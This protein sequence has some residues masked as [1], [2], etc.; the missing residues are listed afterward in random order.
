MGAVQE[1]LDVLR[2]NDRELLALVQ[3]V[4]Y[5]E[6]LAWSDSLTGL[7]NRRGFNEE[8]LREDARAQRYTTPVSVVLVDVVGLK[9]VNDRYGHV[10]GD[11]LL[12]TLGS[13]LRTS[14]RDSD[15]VARLGGDEFAAILPDADEY[16]AQL[17]VERVRSSA[18]T[19]QLP[20]GS[21]VPVLL[22]VGIAT[23]A[24]AGS[25]AAAYELADQRLILAKQHA[26]AADSPEQSQSA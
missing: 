1:L 21:L 18:Q 13:A 16:G 19:A 11:A 3:R 15:V 25:L 8:L 4:K 23:R 22:T 12:R 7:R 5:L 10:S 6:L 2:Q 14:A 9:R 17:F 24:E 26:H 20:D